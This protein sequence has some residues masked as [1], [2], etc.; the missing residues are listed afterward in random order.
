MNHL[1]DAIRVWLFAFRGMGNTTGG[2]QIQ[3][4]T[5][6]A[7]VFV[8]FPFGPHLKKS[9][10]DGGGFERET[11]PSGPFSSSLITK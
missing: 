3:T 6:A 4:R 8:V 11:A 1:M 7:F 9:I 5:L 10:G 2:R